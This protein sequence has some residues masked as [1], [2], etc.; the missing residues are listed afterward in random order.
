MHELCYA[1]SEKPDSGFKYSGVLVSNCDIHIDTYK[2]AGMV[3][4]FGGNNHGSI[5]QIKDVWYI[6]YHRQTNGTWYSRQGCAERLE[7]DSNGMFG[8]AELTSCGLNGGPLN[9]K[10]VHPAYIACNLFKRDVH[11]TY[12]DA[13]KPGDK[14]P[15]YS[16][17]DSTSPVIKQDGKDGDME[18]GYIANIHNTAT[19]G[20]K[21][22]DCQGIS[23]IRIW[24]RGYFKGVF[25][26]RTTWD[27]ECL[28]EVPVEFSNTWTEFSAEAGIPD[29]K[30]AVYLTFRGEGSGC[31][32]AFELY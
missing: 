20:F 29:G 4:A 22:F 21:Y 14:L 1:V 16:G 3:A 11:K 19:A 6:F 10:G 7:M 15:M 12:T 9:G 5:V 28:A 26:M 17:D 32:K 31:L 24:T 23:G 2:P 18:D 30:W 13:Y 27:G 8:Q 25:E